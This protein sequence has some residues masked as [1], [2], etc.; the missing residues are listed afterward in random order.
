MRGRNVVHQTSKCLDFFNVD[1][2]RVLL[3]INDD[4]ARVIRIVPEID[5]NIDLPTALTYP[6]R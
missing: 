3:S 6:Y 2:S 4:P 1:F 5:Q